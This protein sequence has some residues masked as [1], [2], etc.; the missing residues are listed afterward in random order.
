MGATFFGALRLYAQDVVSSVAPSELRVCPSGC[1]FSSIQTAIDAAAKGD[2]VKVAAGVYSDMHVRAGASVGTASV[3]ATAAVTQVV[4]LTK[5]V[6]L[7]GGYDATFAEP[8]NLAAHPT[9]LDAG[10]M[11]RGLYIGG[12]AAPTVEGLRIING[13]ADEGGGVYVYASNPVIR[14]CEVFSNSAGKGGGLYLSSSNAVLEA[15]VVR[16]N[17]ASESA[18]GLYMIF[19]APA[20]DRNQVIDN[21][22]DGRAGGVQVLLSAVRFTNTVV[23]GN[24][25]AGSGSGIYLTTNDAVHLLHT[26]IARNG[27][28]GGQGL[29]LLSGAAYLTNTIVASN[30]V[31]I[32]AASGAQVQMA[33]TLWGSGAWANGDNTKGLGSF[34]LGAINVNG[35][36]AFVAPAAGNY[37]IGPLS[38]AIDQGV[39]AGVDHDLDNESRPAGAA[40]DLGADEN[41]DTV[42]LNQMIYLPA[43]LAP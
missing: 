8:P 12:A 19:G 14:A 17:H 13:A 24:V 40:P 37:H 9:V 27:G 26:T 34:S 29:Y 32:Y 1:P 6:T 4:Y 2:V 18:G 25:A 30:L 42:V 39:A 41:S 35:D 11:G 7:R 28:S 3:D 10:Q 20:L 21:Q 22:S 31:G 38:A 16:N 15:N 5:T 23:A 36:P 33:A 43:V